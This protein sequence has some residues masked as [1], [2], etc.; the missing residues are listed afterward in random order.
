LNA[1]T[2][3]APAVTPSIAKPSPKPIINNEISLPHAPDYADIAKL[4][5]RCSAKIIV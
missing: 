5:V 1:A 2:P 4:K 3:G